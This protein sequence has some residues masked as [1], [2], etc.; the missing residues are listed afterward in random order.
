MYVRDYMKSPVITV[1]REALL[2][3]ALKIMHDRNIRRLPVVENGKLVGLVTEDRIR[4]A[5]PPSTS[6]MS[7]WAFHYYLSKMRV[8]DIMITEVITVSPDATAEEATLLG[9]R[10]N[11][12]SLPVVDKSGN[13]LGIVTAT[14]LI[15]LLTRT[16]GFG[17]KGVRLYIKSASRRIQQPAIWEIL[18]KHMANVRSAYWVSG[19]AD[20]PDYLV[21]HLETSGASAIIADIEKLGLTVEVR[22][23]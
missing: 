7:S 18:G 19:I 21:I 22:E 20:E 1:T 9:E 15:G 4:E 2:D 8:K 6:P 5:S 17:E 12:G 3:E 11:I 16:L 13:L 14:D 23:R 10:N